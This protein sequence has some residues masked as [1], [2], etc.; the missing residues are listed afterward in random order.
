M[1]EISVVFA[2]D[3]SFTGRSEKFFQLWRILSV[4]LESS[5]STE[6]VSENTFQ[7]FMKTVCMLSGNAKGCNISYMQGQ[8]S[9]SKN[10]G[11]GID[12]SL[13]E[14]YIQIWYSLKTG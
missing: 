12:G 14:A 10:L 8:F 9:S 2:Q 1:N 13:Y 7:D 6:W 3:Q 4:N 5:E 11:C